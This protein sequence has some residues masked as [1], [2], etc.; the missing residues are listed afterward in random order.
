V[1][2]AALT[3]LPSYRPELGSPRGWLFGIA[4]H[5]LGDLWQRGVV[6]DRARRRLGMQPLL[7]DD[8]ALARI[9]E[10]AAS[11][12]LVMRLLDELPADQRRAIEGRVLEE[13]S[14]EALAAALRCSP[15]VVRKRVS[16]GLRSL[17]GRLEK[18]GRGEQLR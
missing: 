3:S 2:A 8:P 15:G 10:L 12:G 9:E 5:Q 6:E 16:R 13:R 17:R 11:D 18:S 1:F 14:Y 7:I 4:R